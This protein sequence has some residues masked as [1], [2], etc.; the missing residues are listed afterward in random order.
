MSHFPE[1]INSRET[2]ENISQV[3]NEDKI[4]AEKNLAQKQT[5]NYCGISVNI[6]EESTESIKLPE[7]TNYGPVLS[8]INFDAVSQPLTSLDAKDQQY[9]SS[10]DLNNLTSQQESQLSQYLLGEL[11]S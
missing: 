9:L 10:I 8:K 1:D 6:P 2:K 4:I 5:I 7:N 11:H 3:P